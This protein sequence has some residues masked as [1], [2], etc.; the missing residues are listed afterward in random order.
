MRSTPLGLFSPAHLSLT[1]LNDTFCS[2]PLMVGWGFLRKCPLFPSVL[3]LRGSSCK[4]CF[5]LFVT[6]TVQLTAFMGRTLPTSPLS[7]AD[8]ACSAP[9]SLIWFPLGR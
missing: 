6:R 4:V 9:C 7:R 2:P 8:A 1:A 3:K 5:V